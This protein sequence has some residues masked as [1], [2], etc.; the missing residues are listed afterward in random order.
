MIFSTPR[1]WI[2]A[3][4]TSFICMMAL[5]GTAIQYAN[6]VDRKSNQRWCGLFL[7]LD[8]AYSATPPQN[9]AGRKLAQEIA[10]LVRDFEC[11]K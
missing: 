7:I 5:T 4:L 10:Q 1:S 3:W 8:D 6:Y 11:K 9:E 2:I